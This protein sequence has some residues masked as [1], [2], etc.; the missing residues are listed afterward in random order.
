MAGC[1]SP[2]LFGAILILT[3]SIPA[4]AQKPPTN[5]QVLAEQPRSV[6]SATTFRQARL[7]LLAV[8]SKYNCPSY[9]I[10]SVRVNFAGLQFSGSILTTNSFPHPENRSGSFSIS[11][12]D[13]KG[14]TV[15]GWPCGAE[16]TDGA[17]SVQIELKSRQPARHIFLLF[18]SHGAAEQFTGYL[19]W[20]VSHAGDGT[21]A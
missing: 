2:V 1:K 8:A 16:R 4:A 19:N 7:A 18:S 13:I 14:I 15:Y 20:M 3:F 5:D 12:Q 17:D 11:F 6:E 10:Q 21:R 9:P